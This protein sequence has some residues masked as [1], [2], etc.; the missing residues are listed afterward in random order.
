MGFTHHAYPS[1]ILCCC[2]YLL[3]DF[4]SALRTADQYRLH[5]YDTE[6]DY[7]ADQSALI[8]QI[9]GQQCKL[10]ETHNIRAELA[11]FCIK[12][13]EQVEDTN[14]LREWTVF[15]EKLKQSESHE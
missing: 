14:R 6:A 13:C 11:A 9:D 12:I 3:Q 1:T 10:Q 5:M 4:E 15:Q 2:H 7:N 8:W